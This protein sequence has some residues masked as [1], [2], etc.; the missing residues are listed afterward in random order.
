VNCEAMLALRPGLRI[1]D[2]LKG[3][4]L[5]EK[6]EPH[7]WIERYE[8]QVTTPDEAEQARKRLETLQRKLATVALQGRYDATAQRLTL[9]GAGKRPAVLGELPDGVE[10]H[11][12]PLLRAADEGSWPPL[13]EAF[14]QP[15]LRF[16]PIPRE[17]L[18][19]FAL[20]RLQ[21]PAHDL[22]RCFGIQ[23]D[24]P[25]AEAEAQARDEALSARLLE[26][27]DPNALLLNVLQGLPAG[28]A[29]PEGDRGCAGFGA[30][31][32]LQ[33]A[34]VERVLEACTA[35]PSRIEEIDALLAAYRESERMRSF[36]AFW[37]AFKAALKEEARG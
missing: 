18:C 19:A 34:T 7:P 11:V 27:A 21:D 15:G 10:V 22:S 32:L 29:P 16:E 26:S 2:I 3:F 23:F 24:L 5:R 9:R 1:D 14:T 37:T 20:V 30:Q 13:E 28:S 4:V 35:D 33:L 25:L 31:S 6:D 12:V 8:R 36:T 17:D